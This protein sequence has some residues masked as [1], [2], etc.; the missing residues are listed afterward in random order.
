MTPEVI[1]DRLG[2]FGLCI[3]PGFL[4]PESL[5]ETRADLT[6]IHAAGEF[7]RAGIGQG[8][9][10]QIREQVRSDKIHWLARATANP[11]QT[12]L[13]GKLDS[14]Q[15]A[16]NRSLYLGLKDFEG[17]YAIY[18]VGGFYRRHLD[19]FR[20]DGARTVSCILYLNQDWQKADGGEL[21]I[22][23]KDGS[24]VSVDPVG[25]T[26]VCF[27]SHESEHEVMPSLRTRSSFVGWFKRA[28]SFSI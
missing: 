8:T 24:H 1:A 23:E 10:N 20:H 3:C 12:V 18:P 7:H 5:R 14:L 13:W 19:S 15:L 25:G 17:H 26:M 16:L 6:A 28:H 4:F 2:R 22:Y 11:V 21:R 9:Q 27:L